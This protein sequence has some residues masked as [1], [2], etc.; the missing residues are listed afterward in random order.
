MNQLLKKKRAQQA[1]KKVVQVAEQI[2]RH[3][4]REKSV[5]AQIEQIRKLLDEQLQ[6]DEYFLIVDE[7]GYAVVHT[8]R[9]REGRVFS[10]DVGKKAAKTTEPL[11]QVYMRDTGEILV[12]AS[13]PLCTDK[14][15]KRFNVRMGRLIHQPYLQFH[16]LIQSI[17]PATIS[18]L[19]AFFFSLSPLFVCTLTILFSL[20]I[21]GLFYRTVIKELRHWYSVT[22]TVSSGNLDAEVHTARK[23]NEFHQIAYEL[24]KIILGVRTILSEL[25]KATKTVQHVSEHQQLET[26]RLSESFDE[27]SAAMETFREG[28]KQQTSSVEQAN[29]FVTDMLKEVWEMQHEFESVVTQAHETMK[30]VTEGNR[31]IEMTKQQMNTMQSDM[32]KTTS[33]IHSVS[34]EANRVIEMISAITAIAKQTNLLALNASIEASRAGEAGKG[35]AIVAHEVRKLAEDTNEFAAQILSSLK[36]MRNVLDDAIQAV[37]QNGQNANETMH[38]LLQTS[39]TIETFHQMFSEMNALLLRNREHVDFITNNGNELKQTIQEVNTIAKDFT[40]MVHE[41][42]AGLEQQ[43]HCIHELAKE[44]TL[45]STSIQQLQQIVNRFHQS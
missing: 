24:N 12:D 26:K 35:F 1:L 3:L 36:N 38:S 37:Q 31:L 20:V 2:Q 29:I 4:D 11:L 19:I 7:T 40:N 23:R 41:T 39:K 44:A 18:F 10:D 17:V 5:E 45:L 27:I 13:C 43:I 25:A 32:N 9:L 33:L 22:R 42:T 30:S 21:S 6:Q 14:T 34:K 28:A 15:G 8:N 16:F